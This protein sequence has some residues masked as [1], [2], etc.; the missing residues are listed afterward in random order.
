MLPLRMVIVGLL[1]CSIRTGVTQCRTK[2]LFPAA[3]RT[4]IGVVNPTFYDS[5]DDVHLLFEILLTGIHFEAGGEF[6][7]KDAELASLRKTRHLEVICEE[8]IPRKLTDIYRLTSGLS[9]HVGHLHQEDF[10][11]TLLTLVYVTQQMFN[12]TTE[13]QRDVWA[14]SFVSLYKSIKQDLMGTD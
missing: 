11:R 6:S 4:K 1:Y 13:Q 9:N 3:S 7:V 8:I 2:G 10:E 5:F 14:E 12:T